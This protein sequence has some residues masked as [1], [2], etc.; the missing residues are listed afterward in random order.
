MIRDWKVF[1]L[2]LLLGLKLFQITDDIRNKALENL[3][4]EEKRLAKANFVIQQEN[5]INKLFQKAKEVNKINCSYFFSSKENTAK[6]I[7]KFQT[8]V[9]N[10]A[11]ASGV[12]IREIN[13][14]MTQEKGDIIEQPFSLLLEGKKE[15]VDT[16]LCSI[17]NFYKI[18]RIET[19]S[20]RAYSKR[21]SVSIVGSLLK[22][23]ENVCRT[24][25]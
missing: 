6:I 9:N 21:I 4:L 19:L 24:A 7:S 16:F 25:K 5:L 14:G 20:Y 12:K 18:I 11:K 2:L 23:K 15:N 1:I 3:N 10:S 13:W 17:A 8:Y 22:V